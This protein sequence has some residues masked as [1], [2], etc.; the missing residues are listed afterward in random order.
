MQDREASS[1]KKKVTLAHHK[2]HFHNIPEHCTK[3]QRNKQFNKIM[4]IL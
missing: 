2:S 3:M 1:A 4:S